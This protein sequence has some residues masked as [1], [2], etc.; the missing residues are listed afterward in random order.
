MISVEVA[1]PTIQRQ[2]FDLTLTASTMGGASAT[3]TDKE[4]VADEEEE[5]DKEEESHRVG[6]GRPREGEEWPDEEDV[7]RDTIDITNLCKS[8]GRRSFIKRPN[9]HSVLIAVG[10]GRLV[11]QTNS[12]RKRM[13]STLLETPIYKAHG[14][15]ILNRRTNLNR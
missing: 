13:I 12:L 14:P 10:E 7:G 6:E 1:E 2:M 5:V 9:G 15:R 11:Y 3:P 4:S 8:E